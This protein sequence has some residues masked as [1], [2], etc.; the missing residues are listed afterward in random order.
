VL[1]ARRVRRLRKDAVE[2]RRLRE[3]IT[4]LQDVRPLEIEISGEIPRPTQ[5]EQQ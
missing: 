3:T 4:A 2:L 5:K 1:S